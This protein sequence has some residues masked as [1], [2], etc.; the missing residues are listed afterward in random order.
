MSEAFAFALLAGI[1]VVILLQALALWRGN[2][3]KE[4]EMRLRSLQEAQEKGLERLER[5][6]R[7]ELARGR[8]EDAAEAAGR[9][10]ACLPP[11]FTSTVRP[12]ADGI[13]Q[14]FPAE[15]RP[16]S[17]SSPRTSRRPLP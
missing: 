14:K 8:R 10:T 16:F 9:C 11:P 6:L 15:K 13:R 7:E 5:E 4:G 1:V 12:C 17:A 2:R 3:D